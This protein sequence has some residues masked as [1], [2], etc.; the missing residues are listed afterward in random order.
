MKRILW[1]L[2]IGVVVLCPFVAQ[3]QRRNEVVVQMQKLNTFYRYLQGMY[4][5]SLQMGPLVESGIRSMLADLDPHSVYLSAEEMRKENESFDGEFSGIGI[6][7]NMFRDSILVINTVEQG[8]SAQA[9]IKANDRIVEI[10]GKPVVGIGRDDVSPLLRGA[11]GSIVRLGISRRGEP[12]MLYYDVV[13]DNIPI[14]TIDAAFMAD[15][16]IAY[17]KV[18]RFGRTTM[19]EFREAM[20]QMQGAK[21]LILDLCGNG[22]GLLGQAVDMAG[23]FLPE[24]T[25]ITSIEG[26]TIAP[27][28]YR[29]DAGNEF[30]GHVVVLI[31]EASASG[32]EIV[33][34]ALQDWDRAVIV[35]EDSF[36]KGLVQRQIPLG[37]GSAMRLTV[38]RYHTPSGRVI[39]RPYT[40]GDK[41]GYY[42]AHYSRIAGI[43]D[44]LATDSL[45]K[46]R[47]LKSK[48][49]VY[50]G[51]GI[52]PDIVV[53]SDTTQVSNYMIKLLS[54]GL[55][56][57]F[58]M[59]Y[60]DENRNELLS[61]YP[62]YESFEK[63]FDL[64]DTELERLVAMAA[65]A[66]VEYDAEGFALSREIIRNQLSA[67]IAQLLY[68]PSAFYRW[69]NPRQ[70]DSYIK[71][72]ELLAE[73]DK[74][75]A[76][77][78]KP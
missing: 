59:S 10:N 51:G 36:G 45:P 34:G 22:G 65:A 56:R 42:K 30:M 20:A 64:S 2:L 18:N 24:Q 26:R 77:L 8:P 3:A 40:K 63:S 33:A 58:V 74:Q 11:K 35:G 12:T 19:S 62:A 4:V 70:V 68:S 15:E 69:I 75:A 21:S 54:Q 14:T 78:L 13:R 37:D 32:S 43:K 73:W 9:G 47:T 61:H 53:H 49:A 16:S 67:M 25:L 55:Y 57:D 60:L 31:D 7:Y 23:Y 76:P 44:S 29:S 28:G 72:L 50:G 27:E 71:A 6:E 39:Q 41:E 66:G 38:A 48:R 17:V 5:D 46:Y 52:R 1:S